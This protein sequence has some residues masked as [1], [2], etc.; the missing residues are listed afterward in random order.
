MLA[1]YM[2]KLQKASCACQVVLS[3]PLKHRVLKRLGLKVVVFCK[4]SISLKN[5]HFCK[6]A[7][8]YLEMSRMFK[9]YFDPLRTTRS[10]LQFSRDGN[11]GG[12][13]LS[14]FQVSRASLAYGSAF[15]ELYFFESVQY[16]ADVF[17]AEIER[18]RPRDRDS[19]IKANLR[20]IVPTQYVYTLA[21]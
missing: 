18:L 15:V 9:R 7:F 11:H 21:V 6:H 5:I 8:C 13:F 14:S 17:S 4:N 10:S 1:K 19:H 12:A 20:T 3:H 16:A 2:Q